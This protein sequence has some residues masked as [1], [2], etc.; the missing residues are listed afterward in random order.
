[1]TLDSLAKVSEVLHHV[2]QRFVRISELEMTEKRG[3]E[4]IDNQPIQG[5]VEGIL[6]AGVAPWADVAHTKGGKRHFFVVFLS[7][8]L[9]TLLRRT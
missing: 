7:L 3:S 4:I 1:M 5:F 8:G 9:A 6:L 2:T